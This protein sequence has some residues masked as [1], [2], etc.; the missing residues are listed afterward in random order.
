MLD[1]LDTITLV[2]TSQVKLPLS[3]EALLFGEP[4]TE[5]GES[6]VW[7]GIKGCGPYL[8]SSGCFIILLVIHDARPTTRHAK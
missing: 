8:M 7:K 3:S 6:D 1:P 2:P 5:I 4:A